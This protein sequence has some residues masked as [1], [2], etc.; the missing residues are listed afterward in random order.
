L[1]FEKEQIATLQARVAELEEQ[2][3]IVRQQRS[4]VVSEAPEVVEVIEIKGK[5][6]APKP[7]I[8]ALEREQEL[9]REELKAEMAAIDVLL[10]ALDEALTKGAISEEEYLK[11]KKKYHKE[12]QNIDKK[13]KSLGKKK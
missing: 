11:K 1:D 3:A 2:L 8:D 7:K 13:L 5:K 12:M 9:L 6:K 10:F 4:K